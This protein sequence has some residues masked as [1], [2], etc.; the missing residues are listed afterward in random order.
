M[1]D[2]SINIIQLQVWYKSSLQPAVKGAFL[3]LMNTIQEMYIN[4]YDT[5]K[6]KE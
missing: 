5:K 3:R 6:K 1:A 2:R 4:S